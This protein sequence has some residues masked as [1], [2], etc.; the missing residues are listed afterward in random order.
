MG[1]DAGRWVDLVQ[2]SIHLLSKYVESGYHILGI[3]KTLKR[4]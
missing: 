2:P 4:Q 1:I 3:A